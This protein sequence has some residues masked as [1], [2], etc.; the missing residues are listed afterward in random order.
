MYT[1]LNNNEAISLSRVNQPLINVQSLYENILQCKENIPE[2][3]VLQEQLTDSEDILKM[4][5]KKVCLSSICF[6]RNFKR[7]DYLA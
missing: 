1:N 3:I 7:C 5:W 4:F 6:S 2:Q